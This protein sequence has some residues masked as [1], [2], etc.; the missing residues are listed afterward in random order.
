MAA[1]A[2]TA[3]IMA[4]ETAAAAATM[5]KTPVPEDTHLD[6]AA[7][8]FPQSLAAPTEALPTSSSDPAHLAAKSTKSS[9]QLRQRVPN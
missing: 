9:K 1:E 7:T 5:D 4:T 8:D 6:P 3:E 2:G